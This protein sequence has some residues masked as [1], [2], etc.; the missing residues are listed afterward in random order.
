MYSFSDTFFPGGITEDVFGDSHTGQ[1][2]STDK[3]NKH[4]FLD[5]ARDYVKWQSTN[6]RFHDNFDADKARYHRLN[7]GQYAW[8]GLGIAFAGMVI[9]PNYTSSR[10]FYLRK[11][12]VLFFAWAGWSWGRKLKDDH[13]TLTLLRMNDYFPVEVKRAFESKDYRHFALFDWENPGRQLFDKDTGKSL[14]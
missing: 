11:L 13:T 9:N 1:N 2:R 10:A 6:H 7:R 4:L 3:L 5:M 12:N 8:A 14:S